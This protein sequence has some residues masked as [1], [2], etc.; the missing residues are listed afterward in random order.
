MDIYKKIDESDLTPD[1]KLLAKVCG[2]DTT[3]QILKNF[4][5]L[6]FYIPKLTRLDSFIYRYMQENHDR[7]LKE[8]AR[9]LN[10]TEQYLKTLTKRK[11]K[12]QLKDT[13]A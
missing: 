8:L 6:T 3:R 11:S 5:G 7:S 2:M 10:V 12:A 1:L 13:L 4:G 9:E